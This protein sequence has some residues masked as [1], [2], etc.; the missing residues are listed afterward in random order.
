MKRHL[1]ASTLVALSLLGAI[2]S[3]AAPAAAATSSVSGKLVSLAPATRTLT[4]E[5]SDGG[6][7]M[8]RTTARSRLERNGSPVA[9]AALALRDTV[10][11]RFDARW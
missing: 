9:L 6:Q 10:S 8:L 2:L 1:A 3:A 5:R 11:V 4:V 7:L